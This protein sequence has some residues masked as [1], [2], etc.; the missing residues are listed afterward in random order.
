[1]RVYPVFL[2][3]LLTYVQ[4]SSEASICQT[5]ACIATSAGL[6]AV[7]NRSADPCEDFNQFACGK[8]IATARIP[9]DRF[10][11]YCKRFLVFN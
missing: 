10:V 8:F 3:G 5:E 1:M 9:D 11:S 6:L 2:L 4:P 7:M